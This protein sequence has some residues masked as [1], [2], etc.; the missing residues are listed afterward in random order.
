MTRILYMRNIKSRIFS[1]C[2]LIATSVAAMHAQQTTLTID[3]LFAEMPD[4]VLPYLSR[5]NRLDL[6]DFSKASMKAVVTNSFDEDCEMEQVAENYLGICV[7][8]CSIVEMK[9]KKAD[10]LLPDS[11]EYMLYMLK[12][13]GC[14]TK[15]SV[16]YRYTSRWNSLGEEQIQISNPQELMERK[17]P[18]TDE[19]QDILTNISR[20]MTIVGHLDGET[21]WM[22]VEPCLSGCTTDEKRLIEEKI[23]LKTFKINLK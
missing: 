10:R 7:D 5:N 23:A 12:T 19:E 2:V 1:L 20:T 8:G 13:V 14:E 21:D 16:L 9:L 22:T 18:V 6:I 15:H 17:M 3:S 4:S 11:S